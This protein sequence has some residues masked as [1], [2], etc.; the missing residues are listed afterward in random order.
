MLIDGL[1]IN[2]EKFVGDMVEWC[3]K[4]L[5]ENHPLTDE[6]GNLLYRLIFDEKVT[7]AEFDG[8]TARVQAEVKKFLAT[9][10]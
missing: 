9:L 5:G 7:Q 2:V 1:R 6:C 10:H 4:R 3:E 8:T